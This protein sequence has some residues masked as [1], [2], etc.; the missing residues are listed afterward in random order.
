MAQFLIGVTRG[1]SAQAGGN[2]IV[3]HG[4]ARAVAALLSF[5]SYSTELS[6]SAEMKL[7]NVLLELLSDMILSSAVI[8]AW[9]LTRLAMSS[10]RTSG[11]NWPALSCMR[12]LLADHGAHFNATSACL[13]A[14]MLEMGRSLAVV[15]GAAQVSLSPIIKIIY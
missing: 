7:L 4:P 13:G 8:P 12:V 11:N 1:L 2:T 6:G 5:P 9:F 15:T 10:L 3:N 14:A